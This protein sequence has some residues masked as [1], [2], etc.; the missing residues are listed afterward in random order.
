VLPADAW[1]EA[2]PLGQRARSG[3]GDEQRILVHT[4]TA[5]LRAFVICAKRLEALSTVRQYLERSHADRPGRRVIARRTSRHCR[6][7][8]VHQDRHALSAGIPRFSI[9]TFLAFNSE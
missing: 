9:S 5:S 4:E 3:W 1:R 8:V 7:A 2:V 6:V